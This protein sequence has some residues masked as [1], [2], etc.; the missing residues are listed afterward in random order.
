[1]IIQEMEAE[2]DQFDTLRYDIAQLDQADVKLIQVSQRIT[3]TQDLLYRLDLSDSESMDT[4]NHAL[5]KAR[6]NLEVHRQPRNQRK[7]LIGEIQ[8]AEEQLESHFNSY[9]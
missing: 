1:M 6:T 4:L 5:E 9:N 2:L 3:R 7:R 8:H